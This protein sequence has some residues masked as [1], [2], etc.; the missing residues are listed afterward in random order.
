MSDNAQSELVRRQKAAATT[1]VG[2]FV[3]TILLSVVAFVGKRFFR[4]AP[5]PL[6]F[7]TLKIAVVIVGLGAIVLRRTRFSAMRL[8]DIG[9]LNGATGLLKSLEGTTLQV[10]VL[11]ALIAVLG[12]VATLMTGTD[13]Y[14]YW[15]GVVAI[16]V[17][18][19]SY[20]TRSSWERTVR[21]FAPDTAPTSQTPSS[22]ATP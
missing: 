4:Q 11:G 7:T 10:A 17:L 9:A 2:L 8:Q 14:T 13:F 19:Y 18:I 15:A 21:Q 1:V 3:A 16:A 12:F 20:P 22:E 6:V 5:D